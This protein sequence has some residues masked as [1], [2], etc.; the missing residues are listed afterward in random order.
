MPSQV[1][2]LD[3]DDKA[4][5]GVPAG[6]AFRQG[7]DETLGALRAQADAAKTQ[8]WRDARA[9]GA[10]AKCLERV[11]MC[12]LHASLPPSRARAPG[13]HQGACA[14]ARA[15]AAIAAMRAA[16]L[17]SSCGGARGHATRSQARPRPTGRSRDLELSVG[18]QTSRSWPPLENT[19]S[20]T[21]R[22]PPSYASGSYTER[23]PRTRSPRV[24]P[25]PM[26]AGGLQERKRWGVQ[27]IGKCELFY[28]GPQSDPAPC[29]EEKARRGPAPI[30]PRFARL[31]RRR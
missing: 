24:V 12:D 17:P 26:R 9:M 23:G 30:P 22:P 28:H 5:S 19:L 18:A 4:S 11:Q 6:A 10:T 29:P 15:R 3:R 1:L 21:A 2:V 7:L 20:H 25:V 13:G 31:A 8:S 16:R 27:G 14:R